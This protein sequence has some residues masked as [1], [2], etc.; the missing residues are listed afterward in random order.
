MNNNRE[1]LIQILIDR[2]TLTMKNILKEQ[3]F[4][5]GEFVLGRQQ[6]MIIFFLCESKKELSV[7]EIAKFLHV[8]SSAVSQLIDGLLKKKLVSRK[9]NVKDR[10]VINIAVTELARNHFNNFRKKY[11]ASAGKVFSGLNDK[12]VG[13]FIELLS[14]VKI[15][16]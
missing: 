3:N 16:I 8:T 15:V 1:E 14:K 2:L 4:P 5:F 11:L 7:K 12:E 13:Q 10:R 9:E 6:L